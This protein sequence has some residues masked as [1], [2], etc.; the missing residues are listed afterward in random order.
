MAL[1]LVV[2]KSTVAL[3]YFLIAEGPDCACA[4]VY[5]GVLRCAALCC[6]CIGVC[7]AILGCT[8]LCCD[9]LHMCQAVLGC[10]KQYWGV[11]GGCCEAVLGLCIGLLLNLCVGLYWGSSR[12]FWGVVEVTQGALGTG[13]VTGLFWEG[14]SGMLVPY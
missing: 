12:V 8:G 10:S 14:T 2:P 5:W 11:V 13:S 6:R 1:G 4:G 3:P 9:L 7:W